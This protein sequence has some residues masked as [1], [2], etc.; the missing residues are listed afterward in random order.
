MKAARHA[1]ILNIIDSTV[2]ETQDDLARELKKRNHNVTQATI[3]RDIKELRL[4][5]VLDKNGTYRYA[6]V[7]RAETSMFNRFIRI[8]TESVVSINASE[9]LIVVKTINA[10]AGAAAEAIDSMNWPQVLGT[11]AGDNT[12]LV[13]VKSGDAAN[14]VVKKFKAM[15]YNEE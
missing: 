10:S 12:I 8:F 1:M 4:V 5:K 13:V 6:S 3:S 15:V 7:D 14:E 11:V 2:V 9:N